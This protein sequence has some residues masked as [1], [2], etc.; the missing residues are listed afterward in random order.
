MQIAGNLCGDLSLFRTVGSAGLNNRCLHD[1][2]ASTLTTLDAVT[3]MN[4]A[5][6]S[7]CSD[8]RHRF[9]LEWALTL[10]LW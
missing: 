2:A 10:R 6:A 7:L 1:P 9:F 8:S 4:Q 5:A 3:R